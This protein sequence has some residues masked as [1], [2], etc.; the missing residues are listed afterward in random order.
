MIS[1]KEMTDLLKKNVR[2]EIRV[3][4]AKPNDPLPVCACRV[5][6]KPAVPADFVWPL[7]L[8]VDNA[9][10]PL[11][12]MAQFN[13]KDVAPLDKENLLPKTGVL[14][15]FLAL[16]SMFDGSADD[17]F[18]VFYFPDETALKVAEFPDDLEDE[19]RIPEF[20]VNFKTAESIPYW[21]EAWRDAKEAF[22]D[23]DLYNE[24]RTE[25][26]FESENYI[27]EVTTTKLLGYPDIIQ[28]PMMDA[29][30]RLLFQ[31]APIDEEDYD[32][33]IGD[34]GVFYFWIR[35][36]DLKNGVFNKTQ[37]WYQGY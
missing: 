13:L 1:K 7:F 27:G 6:G 33:M 5:G 10:T 21:E 15:F 26:G 14:S 18:R 3:E 12:F 25:L 34:G 11:S 35:K 32:L 4:I 24:C 16:E 30:W 20:A 28:N 37:L 19:N 9:R 23:Y 8:D 31:M 36:E 2:N 22:P 17:D 29:E